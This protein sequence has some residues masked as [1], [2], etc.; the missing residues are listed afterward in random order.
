MA[1]INCSACGKPIPAAP[2]PSWG[3]WC[4]PCQNRIKLETPWYV[5]GMKQSDM[6][7]AE[8]KWKLDH[9]VKPILELKAC[10]F[11][12]MEQGDY[13]RPV[14]GSGPRLSTFPRGPYIIECGCGAMGSPSPTHE[15][16]AQ[17][18]NNRV[19]QSRMDGL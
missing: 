2:Y 9:G 3:E 18:W 16:A 11:C 8:A 7:Q 13:D 12:G 15:L 14:R 1:G 4:V 10:P 6:A 5:P 19:A 17:M